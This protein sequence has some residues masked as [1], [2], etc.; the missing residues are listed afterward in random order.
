MDWRAI[1]GMGV[2]GFFQMAR[3]QD[4]QK[5]TYAY[6]LAAIALI[7]LAQVPR[8]R[9]Q[10]ESL[11]YKKFRKPKGWIRKRKMRKRPSVSHLCRQIGRVTQLRG[12]LDFSDNACRLT[13]RR[14]DVAKRNRSRAW[15]IFGEVARVISR[16]SVHPHLEWVTRVQRVN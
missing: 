9:F 6:Y 15:A 13:I 16:S 2:R 12:A 7:R 5:C 10:P 4:L 14:G 8:G 11:N 3:K 1:A